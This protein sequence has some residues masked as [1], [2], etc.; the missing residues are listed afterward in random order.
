MDNFWT[1][2][3]IFMHKPPNTRLWANINPTLGQ[4]LV[5]AVRTQTVII[6][7][8]RIDKREVEHFKMLESNE[9]VHVSYFFLN[10]DSDLQ[11][12]PL[13]CHSIST[14]TKYVRFNHWAINQGRIH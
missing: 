3:D 1:P 14:V 2:L 7:M 12:S 6:K 8:F 10:S 4:L 9:A 5:F 11:D 13:I